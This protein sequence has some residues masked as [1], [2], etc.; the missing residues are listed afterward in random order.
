MKKR[1]LKSIQKARLPIFLNKNTVWAVF[2]F[3]ILVQI[4]L[5]IQTSTTGA[6]LAA[7]EEQ[8]RELK[9]QNH[10]LNEELIGSSSLTS[11]ESLARELGYIEPQETFYV[12]EA[13]SFAKL[14]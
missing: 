10:E 13:S 11:L 2:I 7:F 4:F 14:P 8:E 5:T 1:M 12:G 9:G 3:F 6:T